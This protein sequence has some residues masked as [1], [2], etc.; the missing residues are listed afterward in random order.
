MFFLIFWNKLVEVDAPRRPHYLRAW[1]VG[2]RPEYTEDINQ[3]MLFGSRA[4]AMS[5]LLRFTY[6]AGK[7]GHGYNSGLQIQEVREERT[8]VFVR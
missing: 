1:H 3:A 4:S 6:T 2:E 8:L 7:Q 5:A